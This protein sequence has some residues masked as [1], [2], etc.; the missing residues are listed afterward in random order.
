[1]I[2][3]ALSENLVGLDGCDSAYIIDVNA[4][5]IAATAET[6]PNISGLE[7]VTTALNGKFCVSPGHVPSATGNY[8]ITYFAP[9]ENG[10]TVVGAVA[11]DYQLENLQKLLVI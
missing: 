2:T 9:I 7:T 3:D 5:T 8:V 1:M 6:L 4:K 11:M 10:D